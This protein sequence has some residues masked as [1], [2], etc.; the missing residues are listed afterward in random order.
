M[1]RL[2]LFKRVAALALAQF[3]GAIGGLAAQDSAAEPALH[4]KWQKAYRTIAESMAMQREKTPLKLE[5]QALMH[6]TNPVRTRDQHG[7]IFL[8]TEEGR[9]AVFGSIWSAINLQDRTMR[10][11]THEFHSLVEAPDVRATRRDQ[12]LWDCRE[13]GV[14]WQIMAEESTPAASRPARLVQMRSITRRFTAR[15][16]TQD[17]S[18]LRLISQPL[19]RYREKTPGAAD[20][21]IFSFAMT[22]DPELLVLIEDR[23]T[24]GK[25]AWYVAFARFGNQAMTL[26][27]GERR[28]WSCERGTPGRSEGRYHLFFGAE[29]MPAEPTTD[30]RPPT[31]DP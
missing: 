1:K 17:E 5:A 20:G 10:V 6:Y 22:T 16:Q 15:I 27:E 11:V 28:V 31:P 3:A 2:I 21:A 19:Y 26:N 4:E 23:E 18:E 12:T 13:P 24:E 7:S 9:P 30:P 29:Q 8:W 25:P 14:S